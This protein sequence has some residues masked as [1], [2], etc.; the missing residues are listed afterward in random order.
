MTLNGINTSRQR[1]NNHHFAD[2]NSNIFYC[3]KKR[4]LIKISL[5]SVSMAPVNNKPAS[6]GSDNGLAPKR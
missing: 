3:I 4:I 5:K 1:Q 6:I 2:S